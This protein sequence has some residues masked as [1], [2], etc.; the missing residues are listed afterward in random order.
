MVAAGTG[1]GW[2]AVLVSCIAVRA[3]QTAVVQ[4]TALQTLAGGTACAGSDL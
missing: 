4:R 3:I 2:A 1:A